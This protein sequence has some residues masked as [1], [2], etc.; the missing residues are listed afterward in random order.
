MVWMKL[1]HG[2]M[3]NLDRVHQL[4]VG[5]AFDPEKRKQGVHE[6]R[7]WWSAEGPSHSAGEFPT[8]IQAQAFLVGLNLSIKGHS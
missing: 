8:K 7:Y 1:K 3:I 4:E 2:V 6:L 5:P